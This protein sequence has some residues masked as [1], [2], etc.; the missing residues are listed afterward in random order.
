MRSIAWRRKLARSSCPLPSF[1]STLDGPGAAVLVLPVTQSS[2]SVPDHVP[3][4]I[5][6]P[7][8]VTTAGSSGR[9]TP[10]V[11]V[12]DGERHVKMPRWR[13]GGR[14]KKVSLADPRPRG[15]EDSI[16]V[17]SPS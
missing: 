6:T 2:P 17:P 12:R 14:G 5:P 3:H 10:T 16:G 7:A 15:R 1:A 4:A 11:L 9:P 8:P 13:K